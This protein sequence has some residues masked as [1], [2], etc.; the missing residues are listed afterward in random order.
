MDYAHLGRPGLLV[1]RI[2]LG[3]MNFGDVTDEGTS[4]EIM[5]TAAAKGVNFFDSAD[6]YG[7][8]Q[9]P[10]VAKGYGTSEEIIGRWL[11]ASVRRDDIVLATKVYQ[12]MGLGPNDR[13]LSAYRIKRACEASLRRLQTDHID[14]YQMHHVDRATPWEE[15]WQAM[16]LAR[17]RM[18]GREPTRWQTNSPTTARYVRTWATAHPRSRSA[19]L[20]HQP[21]VPAV[22]SGPRTVEQ[23]QANLV[24]TSVALDE[25]ALAELDRIRPGPGQAPESYAW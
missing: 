25:R 2:G 16:G 4:F 22:I 5:D 6:V 13:H 23:L 24:V 7:G 8:P 11:K 9:A 17:L 20:L 14:L 21:A 19:W 15:I 10:D 3:T 1:S 18:C 12:P